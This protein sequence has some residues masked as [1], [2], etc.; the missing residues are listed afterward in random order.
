MP[1]KIPNFGGRGDSFEADSTE[2]E[3]GEGANV[4]CAELCSTVTNKR[5]RKAVS[6]A[7]T[8]QDFILIPIWMKVKTFVLMENLF[9]DFCGKLFGLL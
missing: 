8:K 6:T 3:S 5:K 9:C 1:S 7:A 4:C 2:I